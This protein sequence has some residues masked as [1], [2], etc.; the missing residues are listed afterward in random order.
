MILLLRSD[1]NPVSLGGRPNNSRNELVMLASGKAT[2][3]KFS[4]TTVNSS[5]IA[6]MYFSLVP[7]IWLI[8]SIKTSASSLRIG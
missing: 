7:V 8:A 2:A 6:L 1:S 4:G 5:G 3:R